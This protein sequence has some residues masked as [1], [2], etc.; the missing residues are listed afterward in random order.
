MPSSLLRGLCVPALTLLLAACSAAREGER[1]AWQT[2]GSAWRS[3]PVWHDGQAE[4]CVYEARLTLYGQPRSY[5]AVV[6]TLHQ[7]MDPRTTTKS[8]T[9]TG[10][11]V[12]KQIVT[13]RVPTENYD[14]SFSITGFTRS[15]DLSLFKLT[16]AVQEQ[17]GASFT[18]LWREGTRFS[19]LESGYFPGEGLRRG[20]LATGC[21]AF[22]QLPLVLRDFPFEAA[23]QGPLERPLR[24]LPGLRTNRLTPLVPEPR[25]VRYA[26][27]EQLELPFGHVP[28][29]RLDLLLP[30]GSREAT[31]WFH[32]EGGA[33]WLHALVAAEGPG[34]HALA[35]VSHTRGRYWER[36]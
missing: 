25:V 14:Y 5:S 34:G 24:V 30:D 8:D 31:F 7:H 9:G 20:A 12:F 18:Q 1:G 15:D 16:R 10:V 4:S 26:G 32:A 29:H 3:D 6:H 17:C 23:A 27:L 21:V 19:T 35:L 2:T 13:E 36:P 33:P 11:P 28:A 22:D